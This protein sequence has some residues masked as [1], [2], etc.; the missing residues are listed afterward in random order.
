MTQ[1]KVYYDAQKKINFILT[2]RN[3]KAI[4]LFE[5]YLFLRLVIMNMC[6]H[7]HLEEICFLNLVLLHRQPRA[8]LSVAERE[9]P[10]V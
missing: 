9:S 6:I 10:I 5:T 8:Y 2:N 4:C 1:T 3:K 7:I